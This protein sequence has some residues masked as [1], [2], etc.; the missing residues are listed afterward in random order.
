MAD[1]SILKL[2]I[3]KFKST[4]HQIKDCIKI[5]RTKP[6]KLSFGLNS[7]FFPFKAFLII[8]NYFQI[9]I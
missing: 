4:D 2:K 8:R 9:W 1:N 6:E 3:K 7:A 5:N